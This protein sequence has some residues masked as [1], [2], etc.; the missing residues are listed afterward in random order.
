MFYF[1][2]NKIVINVST[3]NIHPN[4][5]QQLIENIKFLHGTYST[6]WSSNCTHLTI[7]IVKLT[8]KVLCALT[9]GQPIVNIKY[10]SDYVKAIKNDEKP[11]DPSNYLPTITESLLSR[12]VP[13]VYDQRRKSLFVNKLFIFLTESTMKN[14]EDAI[15]AAGK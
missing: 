5:K 15:I 3:S 7:S 2:F 14:T 13:L 8:L 9:L 1:R 6:E 12:K 4:D 11:P 10:W